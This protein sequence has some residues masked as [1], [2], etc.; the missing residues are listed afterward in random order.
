MHPEPTSAKAKALKAKAFEK[1][2]M[3]A[4]CKTAAIVT[5]CSREALPEVMEAAPV[6]GLDQIPTCTP[7]DVRAESS[8]TGDSL[9][10][11]IER[12]RKA[13]A[14][15]QADIISLE[16][17]ASDA[18]DLRRRGTADTR[19]A[20]E[21]RLSTFTEK[22]LPLPEGEGERATMSLEEF[23]S[24]KPRTV[25]EAQTPLPPSYLKSATYNP[26]SP[27]AST[28]S[29]MLLGSTPTLPHPLNT[30]SRHAHQR[31]TAQQRSKPAAAAAA[32][33]AKLLDTP[34]NRTGNRGYRTVGSAAAV[35]AAGTA[36]KAA[37]TAW[38]DV[39]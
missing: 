3:A 37:A 30:S 31:A 33:A 12:Q 25:R 28:A 34:Y 24:Q 39:T 8:Q 23:M 4:K 29:R 2:A 10:Q 26:M 32:I 21:H 15:L 18:K 35:Q 5:S 7:H 9:S 27:R 22:W 6:P 1:M 14:E 36:F 16:V 19:A 13:V 20:R 17:A 38:S 11:F